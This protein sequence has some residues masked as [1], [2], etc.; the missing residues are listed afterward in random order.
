MK[1]RRGDT[2]IEV[3][4]SMAILG[5]IL[6]AAYATSSLNL[7][8]SQFT[9]ERT[10]AL[11]LAEEQIELMRSLTSVDEQGVLHGRNGGFCILS[12]SAGSPAARFP[13]DTN[14]SC[15]RDNRYM[16]SVNRNQ[17]NSINYFAVLVSWIPPAGTNNNRAEVRLNYG[18]PQP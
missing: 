14:A 6:S 5:L 8:T 18:F 7:R 10:A 12:A 2:I 4:I 9:Q 1:I 11:K 15:L 3:L 16:I 17:N 13:D